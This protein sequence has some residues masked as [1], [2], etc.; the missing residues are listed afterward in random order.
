VAY[1]AQRKVLTLLLEMRCNSFCVF[2]GSREVDEAVVRSRRR[3]GLSTPETSF[4]ALRGRYTLESAKRDLDRARS[5]G[6]DDLSIQGGEPTLFPELPEVIAHARALDFRFIGLVTNGRKL[7]DLAF[8][9]RVMSAGLHGITLS[10][11]GEDAATHDALQAVDGA[12][13]DLTRGLQNVSS[14]SRERN[15]PVV[16][17]VNLILS[18]KSVDA[19]PGMVRL[20]AKLGAISGSVHLIKFVNLA[21]DPGVREPLRFDARRLPKALRAGFAAGSECGF[22]M[23]AADI[24]LCLHPEITLDEVRRA[25]ARAPAAG[26]AY[27]AA[28]FQVEASPRN[29]RADLAPC[30]GCLVAPTCPRIAADYLPED[31]GDALTP[32]TA[33]SVIGWVDDTLANID[34][35]ARGASHEVH[36][37][38][39]T[40]SEL[41]TLME[42]DTAGAALAGP[43]EKAQEALADLALVAAADARLGDAIA[44]VLAY[45]GFDP[46]TA[47]PAPKALVRPRS[48]TP[49][50][51]ALLRFDHGHA[52]WLSGKWEPGGAF[53][54]AGF[55]PILTSEP[56]SP[57]V[58]RLGVLFATAVTCALSGA[59]RVRV[60]G[61]K[62]DVDRGQGWVTVLMQV[63]DGTVTLRGYDDRAPPARR[64]AESSPTP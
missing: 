12:F 23:H 61:P 3:L 40:L 1:V 14:I 13:D 5:A 15:L 31:P 11:L 4:G 9:E 43:R 34:P 20:A 22:R 46:P 21:A 16:V 10:L 32:I 56:T 63:M 24:P 35:R 54:V 60:V 27:M 52:A 33:A 30:R 8:A 2:C 36:S 55:E 37:L 49:S 53:A 44:A 19:L 50:S 59:R 62:V 51:G 25:K 29:N 48:V 42:R 57:R 41:E 6:Y 38:C 58:T 45:R 7:R 28:A 17:N 26:H 39:R 64:T 18:A 47:P